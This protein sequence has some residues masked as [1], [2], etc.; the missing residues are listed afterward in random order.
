VQT[1]WQQERSFQQPT[2]VIVPNLPAGG[3]VSPSHGAG[4]SP[5]GRNPAPPVVPPSSRAGAT[6]AAPSGGPVPRPTE[7]AGSSGGWLSPR[8][9]LPVAALG[10]LL[11]GGVTAWRA[12]L[13]SAPPRPTSTALAR[14]ATPRAVVTAGTV[15]PTSRV[16]AAASPRATAAPGS[17]A[18]RAPD[19]PAPTSGAVLLEEN[20][21]D[22]ASG[23]PRQSS[24]PARRRVGYV[25]GEYA[26]AKLAGSG[27]PPVVTRPG[28]FGDFQLEVDVRL[29]APT[30]DGY[31]YIDF[32]RQDNDDHY[33]LLVDPN[34]STFQLQRN[35]GRRSQA[36]IDWTYASA[37]RGG[38]VR[39][40]IGIRARGADLTV[41]ANGE[42]I[43]RA[44]D[45]T[46]RAGG[47]GFGVDNFGDGTSEV[48]FGNLS[49][50]S[51]PDRR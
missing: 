35:V 13:A 30:K 15:V 29:L 26:I 49:V 22:P 39:N 25:D 14:T 12:S 8:V 40:R 5:G 20:F 31:A 23:W 51:L 1:A 3:G 37:I 36:L 47:L 46:L 33:S 21:R 43:G 19:T 24:D 50:R 2:R 48:R 7:P 9:L 4:S 38:T 16:T 28:D 41:L 34:D 44:Q 6:S 18:T 17:A 42:E 11:L 10:L 32:R 45:S 27:N